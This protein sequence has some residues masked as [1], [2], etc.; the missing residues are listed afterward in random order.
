MSDPNIIVVPLDVTAAELNATASLSDTISV[1]SNTSSQFDSL[2]FITDA[3]TTQEDGNVG[4]RQAHSEA[5]A[6]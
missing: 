6:G 3:D 2:Q 4:R 5:D 1:G